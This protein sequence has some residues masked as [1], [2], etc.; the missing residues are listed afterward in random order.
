[1]RKL[2]TILILLFSLTIHV[3]ASNVQVEIHQDH[4]QVLSL[5]E[6]ANGKTIDLYISEPVWAEVGSSNEL[7]V[8]EYPGAGF[9]DIPGQ[10]VVPVIGRTVRMPIT[11]GG[12]IEILDYHYRVLSDI[13]YAAFYG[14]GLSHEL[15][16][17]DSSVD[18]WY[19][20][21]VVTIDT[22]AILK[23][24]R[25]ANVS[26]FPVQVNPA[27]RQVR[28]YDRLDYR[29][30]YDESTN[31]NSLDSWPTKL[32]ETFMPF[33][34]SFLDWSESELDQYELYRGAVQLVCEEVWL[35]EMQDWITWKKQKGW[36][37]QLLTDSD[38]NWDNYSIHNELQNRYDASEI[39]F[40][41]IVI[42]GDAS[43]NIS[44]P[45][46]SGDLYGG[47]DHPYGI[48]AGDD[49]LLDASVGRISVETPTMLTAYVRKVLAY[50]KET[51]TSDNPE[52]LEWYKR[53]S[54]AA[55]S[56]SSGISTVYV[57][58]Y[59][60]QV[61]LEDGYTQ[62]DTAFFNDGLGSVNG[63]IINQL[64]N[65]VS[66]HLYRGYL[67]S[68][69]DNSE[70]NSLNNTNML[71]VVVDITCARGN[72]A[73]ETSTNEAYMR[74]GNVNSPK[75]GIAAIST[76]TISTHTRFNNAL[77]GGAVEAVFV[78]KVPTIGQM[79]VGAKYNM[80][81]NFN[82]F[83]NYYIDDFN[84][85]LNLMGDP[86]VWMFTD[87][88][89]RS[90]S[91]DVDN[92]IELGSRGI[93]IVVENDNGLLE[94]AWVTLYKSDSREEVISRGV[95]DQNGYVFLDFP[96]QYTGQ[97]VITVTAYNH[98]PVQQGITIQLPEDRL[99]ISG[100][101]V[102]DDGTSGT[103]GNGNGV[104]EA[105]ETVGL[106]FDIFNY[107][108]SAQTGIDISA[109][110]SDDFIL[111]VT[112]NPE[113][114][115]LESYESGSFFDPILVEIDTNTPD[116]WT[117]VL[118][119]ILEGSS[120]NYSD[121]YGIK[122]NA[123]KLVFIESTGLVVPGQQGDVTFTIANIGNSDIGNTQLS[124]I[125]DDIQS[126][127]IAVDSEAGTLG[128]VT[129]GNMATTS[130]FLFTGSDIAFNGYQMSA[131]I[132]AE[133]SNG[134]IH[135]I[136]VI[137][138]MGD[139]H[140]YD[141]QGPDAY[142]YFAYDNSDTGYIMCPT[143]DWIEIDPDEPDA[144]FQGSE[145]LLL[146]TGTNQD[147]SAVVELPFQFTYYGETYNTITVCSNGWLAMGNQEGMALQRNWVIPSPLGPSA[148]IAP[149]W[150]DR[151]NFMEE[152]GVFYHYIEGE[153]KFVI[154]WNKL[155]DAQGTGS[156]T[157]QVVLYENSDDFPTPTGDNEFLFQYKDINPST[158][159]GSD[160]P[161]WTTGIEN[162]DQQVGLQLSYY[163]IASNCTFPIEDGRSILFSTRTTFQTGNVSGTVTLLEDDTPIEGVLV[164]SSVLGTNDITDIN[165]NYSIDIAA[166][167]SDIVFRKNGYVTVIVEDV[168]VP[169]DGSITVNAQM[170]RPAFSLDPESLTFN[171]E[172]GEIETQAFTLINS[173]DASLFYDLDIIGHDPNGGTSEIGDRIAGFD[174]FDE[175]VSHLDIESRNDTLWVLSRQQD[176][177]DS[178]IKL[179]DLEGIELQ[180]FR[181]PFMLDALKMQVTDN[182]V[183]LATNEELRFYTVSNHLVLDSTKAFPSLLYGVDFAVDYEHEKIYLSSTGYI[184]EYDFN[185][186]SLHTHY[187]EGISIYGMDV[188]PN[189]PDGYTL[190]ANAHSWLPGQ[191]GNLVFRYDPATGRQEVMFANPQASESM[192]TGI[193]LLGINNNMNYLVGLLFPYYDAEIELYQ[194]ISRLEWI[195]L[196]QSSGDIDPESSEIV[197]T[198]VNTSGMSS[199]TYH[200]WVKIMHNAL[201][202]FAY[203]PITLNIG[204]VGVEDE[205]PIPLDWA[206]DS[207][208]PN[209][210]NP[211]A[212]VR[213]S[214]LES[215]KVRAKLFN[216]L[217]QQVAV[218]ANRPM[219]AGTHSLSINGTN[220]SSGVYFLEFNAGPL[221]TVQKVVL[222]K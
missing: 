20:E 160:V 35:D 110:S 197:N 200:A 151:T 55:G 121:A 89:N 7:L 162:G 75:G 122:I 49:A 87:I 13:D 32:S 36:D 99:G 97:A 23:D 29:I 220:L 25:V 114:T 85:W 123:P 92:E 158:G 142:G 33:Y 106:L 51:F 181:M 124:L 113:M 172:A 195:S 21:E 188:L 173:G 119:V 206:L 11:G 42:V 37:V 80:W 126:D 18:S 47:G 53:G 149:F 175:D 159:N 112:G 141:P 185:M 138:Q 5:A 125:L 204:T 15:E 211:V 26:T 84:Q 183:I 54:V 27:R 130:S 161:Y 166:S 78:H 217:G 198:N 94:N 120:G 58:R 57:A 6:D 45:P 50:E 61:M 66:F 167:S 150:D 24:F 207:V 184:Y 144:I 221:S 12:H 131:Q 74:A 46:G 17:L 73:T 169:V 135:E 72:W 163:N 186:Q 164:S 19:P 178:N 215:V 132:I 127:W 88:P 115:S 111:S 2:Q 190:T 210:F 22:P 202:G 177:F 95:T 48:L 153:G 128:P 134:Q 214:L 145:L 79:L 203:L 152:D 70:I 40:D 209:P 117:A 76:A 30:V 196:D 8:A 179:Y 100:F 34:R 171:L 104:I 14:E 62:V 137:I 216:V 182:I 180:N 93:E 140:Q 155:N 170:G 64:N 219:Q 65:G 16:G 38:V 103:S 43:G 44:T 187:I 193:T 116:D 105:G 91:F 157:F 1:M 90:I 68:G 136:P 118:D 96:C 174:L 10:P 201:G 28:V 3:N 101:T 156:C 176:G 147:V 83:Q 81:Q 69:L 108:N 41:H 59:S 205:N 77:A 82:G 208:Y 143:Y 191:S 168:V 109:T 154:E 165:G 63:R 192:P 4:M 98:K 56:S 86:T 129:S 9:V 39:K 102:L 67:G 218:L 189:E 194:Y 60:R 222:M 133:T 212:T 71:P 139:G 199:G 52:D 213:F 146:D 148:M 31:E 107:G